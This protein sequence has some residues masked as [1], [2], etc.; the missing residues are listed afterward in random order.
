MVSISLDL[1]KQK[2]F[3]G[4]F[5]FKSVVSQGMSSPDL[6]SPE[7]FSS[8]LS[9]F[10]HTYM[11]TYSDMKYILAIRIVLYLKY[12]VSVNIKLKG[13]LKS[14][15]EDHNLRGVLPVLSVSFLSW[16]WA[17]GR[18]VFQGQC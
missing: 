17:Q 2:L 13:E 3:E 8:V 14:S 6:F 9:L 1:E 18:S 7:L 15:T 10:Q 5:M 4:F 16:R 12:L 11:T